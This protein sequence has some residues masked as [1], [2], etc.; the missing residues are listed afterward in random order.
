MR[1]IAAHKI[2]QGKTT[3]LQRFGNR[4]GASDSLI[5]GSYFGWPRSS[6]ALSHP[7]MDS[8]GAADWPSN[9]ADQ[10]FDHLPQD[11]INAHG[12]GVVRPTCSWCFRIDV[13]RG[14]VELWEE[15]RADRVHQPAVADYVP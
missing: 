6:G 13:G 8:D 11:P 12:D 7:V 5:N 4:P 14:L 9:F 1:K 15:A 3:F 2:R 10:V